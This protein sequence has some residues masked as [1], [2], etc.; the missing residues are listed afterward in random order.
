MVQ[1][2]SQSIFVSSSQH[3]WYIV[4]HVVRNVQYQSGV[5]VSNI[6]Q[7]WDGDS[8][9]HGNDGAMILLVVVPVCG[10]EMNSDF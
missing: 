6:T 2:D 7:Y 3:C 5:F 8:N 10:I 9:I 4:D 1:Y